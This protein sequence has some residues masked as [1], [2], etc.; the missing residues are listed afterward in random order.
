MHIAADGSL[1]VYPIGVDRVCHSW[2]ANP[3]GA[4][5]SPWLEPQDPLAMRLIEPP[6]L[7]D[8]PAAVA[9]T[10]PAGGTTAP[11]AAHSPEGG[12]ALP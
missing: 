6:V 5:D 10:A 1:T 2:T 3:G 8:G 9:T 12:G 4:P 7:V 11:G